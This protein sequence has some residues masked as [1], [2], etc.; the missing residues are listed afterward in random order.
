MV[1]LE[2]RDA[3][4]ETIREAGAP[5]GLTVREGNLGRNHPNDSKLQCEAAIFSSYSFTIKSN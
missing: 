4:K 1:D 5:R 3:V 2:E